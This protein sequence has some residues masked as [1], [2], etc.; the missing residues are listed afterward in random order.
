[1]VLFS[2]SPKYTCS[3]HSMSSRRIRSWPKTTL[4]SRTCQLK[5]LALF[6]SFLKTYEKQNFHK[7]F[8]SRIVIKL[9]ARPFQ[10]WWTADIKL[11]DYLRPLHR[12]PA[13]SRNSEIL[14]W[15]FFWNNYACWPCSSRKW[16]TI[17]P[18]TKD[19]QQNRELSASE[20]RHLI[21][22]Y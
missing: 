2:P 19:S 9:V 17:Q 10:R 4:I 7:K 22:E 12:L 5:V 11:N 1:M 20:Q 8:N 21:E 15:L 14:I 6:E 18:E 16:F 13:R 3:T